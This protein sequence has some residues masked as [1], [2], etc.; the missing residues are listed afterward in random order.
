[1]RQI[2]SRLLTTV[3]DLT[4][5]EP[6]TLRSNFVHAVKTMPCSLGG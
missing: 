4:V 6:E 1:L 5:G 3:P 2:F